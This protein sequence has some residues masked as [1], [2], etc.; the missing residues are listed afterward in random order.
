MSESIGT[1]E[2]K[3]FVGSVEASDAMSKA[4]GVEIVKQVQ[5]GGGFLTVIVKGDVGSVKAAVE[6]GAEAANRVGELVSSNI[7]ARPHNDL[8]KQ[9]GF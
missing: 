6:A 7:I 8:L 9:F 3:G 5:I 2:T 1:I 4:A